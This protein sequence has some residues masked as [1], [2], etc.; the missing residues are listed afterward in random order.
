M[1]SSSY[2]PPIFFGSLALPYTY[3]AREREKDFHSPSRENFFL[4][5]R[6][7]PHIRRLHVCS[8]TRLNRF[9]KM[10]R[11]LAP[12]ARSSQSVI[13]QRHVF[14]LTLARSLSLSSRPLISFRLFLLYTLK[15]RTTPFLYGSFK[16]CYVARASDWRLEK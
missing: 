1:P 15:S 2:I 16:P 9:E 12:W 6:R 3:I 10:Q 7:R 11:K 8:L 14:P 5:H 4:C 13:Q